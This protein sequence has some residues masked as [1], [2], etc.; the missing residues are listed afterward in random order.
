MFGTGAN[1]RRWV[2]DLI[3][4][5]YVIAR[6]FPEEK[7]KLDGLVVEHEAA[8]QA[9]EEYLE[10]HAVED[11]A[12]WEA[13]DDEGKV[14]AKLAKDRLKAA[15]A[16]KAEAE[17]IEALTQVIKLFAAEAAA[18][19][20]VKDATIKLHEQ[21]L[22]HYGKLTTEDVQALVIDDK[23]GG[24]ISARIGA[25]VTTLGQSLIGRLR[26]L[27]DRY[28]STIAE[29]DLEVDDLRRK[30]AAHLAAMGVE[31]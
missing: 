21:A 3:P 20:A 4:P 27:A 17:E 11:G 6:F 16:E 1:A 23:W 2:M 26:L 15:K 9:V 18:K 30:V 25:E 28:E 8:A 7:A 10:E 5:E 29:I 19:K 31:A 13:A 24:T 14:S 12:L 22:A